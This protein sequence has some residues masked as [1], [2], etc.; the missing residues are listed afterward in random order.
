MET[1]TKLEELIPAAMNGYSTMPLVVAAVPN[2]MVP[3]GIVCLWAIVVS[4]EI[5][6]CAEAAWKYKTGGVVHL[7]SPA[8]LFVCFCL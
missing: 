3:D 6:K 5:V 7:K 1:R 8:G 2:Y 4:E